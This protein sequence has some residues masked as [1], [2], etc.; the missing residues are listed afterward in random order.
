MAKSDPKLS[1]GARLE[2]AAFRV[3]LRRQLNTMKIPGIM[4]TARDLALQA[5][6]DWVLARQKRYDKK[7]GGLGKK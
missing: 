6:L 1:E 2:R 3:Y 5:A 4:P 7:S